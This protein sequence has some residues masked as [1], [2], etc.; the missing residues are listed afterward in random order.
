VG[1]SGQN[2]LIKKIAEEG[3]VGFA[4]FGHGCP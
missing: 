4:L 3:T 1:S 2:L